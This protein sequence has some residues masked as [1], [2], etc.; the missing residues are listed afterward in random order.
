MIYNGYAED[1]IITL[2]HTKDGKMKKEVVKFK[3]SLYFESDRDERYKSIYGKNLKRREYSDIYSYNSGIFK[4]RSSKVKYYGDIDPLYQY[5][6]NRFNR[7]VIE[8]DDKIQIYNYDIEAFSLST[9]EFMKPEESKAPVQTI[10][11][12]EVHNGKYYVFGYEDYEVKDLVRENKKGEKYIIKKEDIIYEK[13][14]SEVKLLKGFIKFLKHKN[15]QILTGYNIL[16]YDNQYIFNRLK[17]LGIESDFVDSCKETRDGVEFGRIQSLDYQVL[18]KKFTQNELPK[19]KLDYV[20]EVELGFKKIDFGYGGSFRK[21]YKGDFQKFIDYNIVDTMLVKLLEEKL[22]YIRLIFTMCNRFRCLPSDVLSL[23]KYWD[24][25]LYAY[26]LERNQIVCGN[27]PSFKTQYI[28][29][30]VKQPVLGL[31]D[32]STLYDIESSYPTNNRR[33]NISP[34]MIIDY[35]KLPDVF[36]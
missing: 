21:A 16:F 22:K 3:P 30:Y 19:Y 33:H 13:F 12:N 35:D 25:Y 7:K 14:S 9:D 31:S 24:T 6:I 23:T 2:F 27:T 8:I 26:N 11:I 32:W 18:Y 10:T 17:R 4:A 36:I 28:G 34:E 15:V 5:I 1:G 20:S 29:G